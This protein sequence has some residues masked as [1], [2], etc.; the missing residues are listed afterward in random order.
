MHLHAAA[1][2]DLQNERTDVDARLCILNSPPEQG[3][4]VFV[5]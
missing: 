1:S 4:R 5:V 2:I 3:H